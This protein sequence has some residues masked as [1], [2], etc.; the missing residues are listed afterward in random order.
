MEEQF[1]N[2]GCIGY[3][4][5]EVSNFGRVRNV[6]TGNFIKDFINNSHGYH[7]IRLRN[8]NGIKS[9]FVARLVALAFIP[10]PD[11]KPEV[12]HIDG[13]PHNNKVNN[14]R[15]VTHSE[16]MNNPITKERQCTSMQ[17]VTNTQEYK[18]ACSA[19]TAGDKNPMFGKSNS[20]KD[21][22]WMT[23]GI[24]EMRVF[25]PWDKDMLIF[26]WRYGQAP[27][28]GKKQSE[29]KKKNKEVE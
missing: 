22:K 17:R 7:K 10:N 9:F 1:I 12:D 23:N 19:R 28:H 2:L 4:K 14:L 20:N 8:E 5:Y 26:G 3:N 25:P 18:D 11:N 13:N 24:D 29:T 16:N 6:I 27:S 15:W 21:T